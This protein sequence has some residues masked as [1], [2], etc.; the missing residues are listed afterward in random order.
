MNLKLKKKLELLEWS[1]NRKV[2][3]E[4]KRIGDFVQ[5]LLVSDSLNWNECVYN[6]NKSPNNPLILIGLVP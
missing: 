3:I 1:V 6:Y 4:I 2:D 5:N